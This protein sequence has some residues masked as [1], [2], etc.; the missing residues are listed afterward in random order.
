MESP[1]ELPTREIY[2]DHHLLEK[3]AIRNST[4]RVHEFGAKDHIS[5]DDMFYISR[6]RMS[7]DTKEPNVHRIASLV[8]G[9]S[10][11]FK[12]CSNLL[13][14]IQSWGK[15]LYGWNNQIDLGYDKKWLEP[16]VNHFPNDWCA[17][18]TAL[19]QSTAGFNKYQMMIFLSTSMYSKNAN[20]E[21]VQTLLSFAT[22][23]ELRALESPQ[24]KCCRNRSQP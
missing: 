6:D 9:W 16:I 20:Q 23:P 13:Q 11:N 24:A 18:Q 14:E 19:L 7:N 1:T 21:L 22:V 15:T 4:Y 12:C 10:K 17:L 5:E 8:D 2:I 3:A